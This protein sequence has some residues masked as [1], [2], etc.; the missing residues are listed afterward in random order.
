[1]QVFQTHNTNQEAWRALRSTSNQSNEPCAVAKYPSKK[2]HDVQ[3]FQTHNSFSPLPFPPLAP[4][5]LYSCGALCNPL[6]E[7]FPTFH[8]YCRSLFIN[9]SCFIFA[10][11]RRVLA[12][13]LLAVSYLLICLHPQNPH[14]TPKVINQGPFIFASALSRCVLGTHIYLS[15]KAAN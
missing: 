9:Q 1:M 5:T 15:T 11:P 2:S 8:K 12:T 4:L 3:V 13:H 14:K 7:E 6:P 10:F